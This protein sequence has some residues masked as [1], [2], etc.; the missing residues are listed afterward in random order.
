MLPL[1]FSLTIRWRGRSEKV[2]LCLFTQLLLRF[3]LTC[4]PSRGLMYAG[5]STIS[6]KREQCIARTQW[7]RRAKV[8]SQLL[9]PA[10]YCLLQPSIILAFRLSG[11]FFRI[12]YPMEMVQMQLPQLTQKAFEAYPAADRL[13]RLSCFPV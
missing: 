13:L 10:A 3:W 6:S 7:A 2:S 12:H 1:S 8:I 5:S 4:S 9:S 11:I